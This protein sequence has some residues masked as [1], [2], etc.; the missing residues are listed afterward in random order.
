MGIITKTR[1]TT[2]TEGRLGQRT[3]S[4]KLNE[5]MAEKKDYATTSVF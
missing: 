1:L 4:E 5:A 3:F 2:I